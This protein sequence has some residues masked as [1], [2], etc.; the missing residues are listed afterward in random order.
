MRLDGCA[1]KG[2]TYF[3]LGGTEDEPFKMRLSAVRYLLN[4]KDFKGGKVLILG[5][6]RLYSFISLLKLVP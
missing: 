4:F 3:P 5:G 2:F 6:I 1:E